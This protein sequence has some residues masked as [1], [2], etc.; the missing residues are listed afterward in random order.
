MFH[1]AQMFHTATFVTEESARKYAAEDHGSWF[2]KD[3][4]CDCMGWWRVELTKYE[5]RHSC[6]PC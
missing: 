2:L 1:T 3:V 6:T 4:Y 5:T